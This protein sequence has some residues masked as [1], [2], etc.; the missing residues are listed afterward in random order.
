MV[1]QYDQVDF[2]EKSKDCP[3]YLP[4]RMRD[5][6]KSEQ[7]GRYMKQTYYRCSFITYVLICV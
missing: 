2:T 7:R 1:M 3:R 6:L 5:R 4:F